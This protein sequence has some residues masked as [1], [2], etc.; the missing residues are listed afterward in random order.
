MKR[1]LFHIQLWKLPKKKKHL[2]PYANKYHDRLRL[3][4]RP[5]S[6]MSIE[7]QC[8]IN[9]KVPRN[10]NGAHVTPTNIDFASGWYIAQPQRK[11]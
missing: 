7:V 6:N 8:Y 2:T 5:T 9:F 11:L 10:M 4:V 1:D 3:A